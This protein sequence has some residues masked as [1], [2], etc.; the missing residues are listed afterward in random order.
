MALGRGGQGGQSPGP[1]PIPAGLGYF[2]CNAFPLFSKRG[3]RGENYGSDKRK[4]GQLC[5]GPFDFH[6]AEG[7]N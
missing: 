1:L 6:G 3:V 4:K 2:D 7:Q 5:S